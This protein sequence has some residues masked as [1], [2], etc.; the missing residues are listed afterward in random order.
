MM[1]KFA[2]G[3]L[4]GFIVG[5]V[6]FGLTCVVVARNFNRQLSVAEAKHDTGLCGT[7]EIVLIDEGTVVIAGYAIAAEYLNRYSFRTAADGKF[8]VWHRG[9]NEPKLIME[10]P[11]GR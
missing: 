1:H 9:D 8:Q 10:R 11:A 4:V 5:A 7:K 3:F 2:K 6:I